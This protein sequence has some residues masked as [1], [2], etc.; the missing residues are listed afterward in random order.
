MFLELKRTHWDCSFEYPKYVFWLRNKK[1]IFLFCTPNKRPGKIVIIFL[2]ISFKISF[3][4]S[5]E[6]SQC[7]SHWAGSL[8]THNTC[9][10]WEIKKKIIVNYALLSVGLPYAY[11]SIQVKITRKCHNHN[12]RSQTNLS[13]P[14]TCLATD[15]S[16]TADLGVAS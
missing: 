11:H 10:G 9:F 2:P 12:H 8:S 3:G 13:Q 1:I 4:C 16:L 7:G 14:V 5:K 6:P 15:A